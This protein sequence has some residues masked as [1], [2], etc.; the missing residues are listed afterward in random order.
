[1]PDLHYN[2]L[3]IVTIFADTDKMN[4]RI[5]PLILIFAFAPSASALEYIRFMYMDKERS[6]EGRIL[7]EAPSGIAF[8]ARDG[9]YFVV[10]PKNLI[11]RKS[12]DVPFVPYTKSEMLDRLKKE[13][14]SEEGYYYLDTFDP[15]IIVYTTSRPFATWS[16]NLLTKLY[17]QYAVHWKRLGVELNK[18]EFPLVAIILSNKERYQQYAKQD[19]V[20]LLPEQ[21]AYYHKL[22]N[23]IAV[24]D[25]SGQQA[26]QEG[27]QKRVSAVDIQRLLRQ[28]GSYNNVM[29]VIH[30]AVHQ[31][32][33]NTGMHPRFTPTPFWLYEGL[34]TLHEVPDP[35]DHRVGWTLGQ[36][37][38]NHPRLS[39]L[40]HYF[41]TKDLKALQQ[42]SPIQNMIIE[43]KLIR[44]SDTA[45]DNYA[46]AWGLTYYLV[47]KRPRELA[48]YLKIMQEKAFYS[49]DSDD[50]RLR[51]FTSCFGDDW[52]KFYKDFVDFMKRL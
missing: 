43:D 3:C 22:T 23:R 46:L 21:C 1:M 44:Q 48:A 26:L 33:F 12:D 51:D 36:P 45:L 19:G 24:Y 11:S 32:G 42:E 41:L 52:E 13:F 14:P 39:Q 40:N 16:G 31:V 28:P 7:L 27:N 17:E 47:K 2:H 20:S 29:S 37:H 10:P 15:F 35:R 8:E 9:R 30:E 25:M 38:I 34:A 50:I 18:T 6:E 4:F 49:Q 5:F